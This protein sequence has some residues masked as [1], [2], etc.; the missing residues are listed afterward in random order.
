MYSRLSA[1]MFPILLLALIGTGVWGYQEHQEKNSIL[2]KAENQYQR[3]FHDLSYHLDK[4]QSELGNTL[5]I[6]ASSQHFFK[7]NLINVWRLTTQAQN[8]INQLP[9]TL[10]PFSKTEEFLANMAN[11]AYQ[12][13]VRDLSQQPLS[14]DEM[15]TLRSLYEYSKEINTD[16]R[17]VQ[18]KVIANRLRWMDV[19]MALATE[20]EQ[21][22]NTIIDGFKAV[23]KK[24]GAY[25]EINW[26]PAG[27]S[28]H[29][30]KNLR[31]LSGN[32]ATPEEIRNKAAALY[33]LDAGQLK[34]VENGAGTEYHT[35]SVTGKRP[36]TDEDVQLDFSKKGGQL[37]WLMANRNVP[38]KVLDVRGARDAAMAF[39][40]E[41]GYTNLTAVSYDEYG[42]VATLTMAPKQGDVIIYPAAINIKVAL[43]DGEVLGLMATDFVYE[44]RERNLPAPKLSADEARKSL[45]PDFA[46]ADH[47]MALIKNDAGQEVLCY[48]FNGKING[49]DFRIFINADTGMEEKVEYVRTQ[50]AQAAEG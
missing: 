33:G 39:L 16:L 26:G 42:N 6:N 30:V 27:E 8:E 28:L 23:D 46:V 1:V 7:K 40:E 29:R 37:V 18:G 9:L 44:N 35:Y 22:D 11:F 48:Q 47:S 31:A 17:E 14:E 3:A 45:N 34:V 38:N 2:I 25:P 50:S 43:D 10:L 15:K 19:E 4:L 20:K 21:R 49:G 41:R 5:A 12:T 13:S 24:V 36:G 32:D